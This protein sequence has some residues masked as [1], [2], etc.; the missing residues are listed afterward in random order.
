MVSVVEAA[1]GCDTRNAL[2]G[3]GPKGGR[4]ERQACVMN[5]SQTL[6]VEAIAQG[7]SVYHSVR[8]LLLHM[9]RS[10]KAHLS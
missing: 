6:D 2:G 5:L 1:G 10:S 3:S 8:H 9:F 7:G 4:M